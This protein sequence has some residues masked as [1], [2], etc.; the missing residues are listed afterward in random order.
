MRGGG[1][2]GGVRVQVTVIHVFKPCTHLGETVLGSARVWCL[3]PVRVV[4]RRVEL[5]CYGH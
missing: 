3:V 2:R 4:G 1:N 5:G